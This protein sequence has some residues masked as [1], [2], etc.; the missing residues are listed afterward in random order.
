MEIKEDNNISQYKDYNNLKTLISD[1]LEIDSN[2]VY[3]NEIN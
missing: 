3:I 2:I 1:Y